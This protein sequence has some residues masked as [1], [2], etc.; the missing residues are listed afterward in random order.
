MAKVLNNIFEEF[1]IRFVEFIISLS[2]FYDKVK[3]IYSIGYDILP[4]PIN[5]IG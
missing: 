5:N 4:L 2:I 1:L 3:L